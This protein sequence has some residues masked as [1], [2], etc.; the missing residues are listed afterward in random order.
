[1]KNRYRNPWHATLNVKKPQFYENDAPCVAE[2]RGVRIYALW[3]NFFDFVLDSCC[4]T[5][6]AGITEHRK[7]IDEMLSGESCVCDEVAAHLRSLGHS[8]MTYSEYGKLW[9]QGKVA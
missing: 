4:I 1:M 7:V 8:P 9:E 2:Y 3:P 6:R 5:Q